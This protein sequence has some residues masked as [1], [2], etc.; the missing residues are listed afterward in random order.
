[1][2]K[3]LGLLI[4]LLIFSSCLY[5]GIQSLKEERNIFKAYF[6]D[7]TG[8]Y[9]PTNTQHDTNLKILK[10]NS[11]VSSNAIDAIKYLHVR[12]TDLKLNF[13]K[14]M[15]I[16]YKDEPLNI[17]FFKAPFLNYKGNKLEL[18]NSYIDTHQDQ[19]LI[20]Q[21]NGLFFSVQIDEFGNNSVLNV[22][23]IKS[24]IIDFISYFEFFSMSKFGLKDI[25]VVKDKLYASIIIEKEP[26]CFTN[27]ILVAQISEILEFNEFF[28]ITD[29]IKQYESEEFNAH[30]TG[31]KMDIFDDEHIIFTTGDF[32]SRW[33]AQDSESLFGKILKINTSNSIAITLAK[34]TRNAQG[35]FVDR[36]ENQI[37]LTE[38]GPQGGD[39]INL[40][41]LN[42]ED[43]NFGWP[44]SSYGG[45]YGHS[46]VNQSGDLYEIRDRSIYRKFPL[47]KSHKDYGFTEP[48]KYFVPS[49]GISDIVKI[50][51]LSLLRESFFIVGAMGRP[52]NATD[53]DMSLSFFEWKQN[54]IE[55]F[56]TITIGERVRDFKVHDNK[57]FFT[58][59]SNALIGL[60]E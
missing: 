23:N 53:Q 32:R 4:I 21:E 37:W 8:R 18:G 52:D 11:K 39:E 5:L 19:L 9:I 25:L 16:D 50:N 1:M 44:I 24:N 57:V 58:T 17:S 40:L 6:S 3:I 56:K 31:G 41:D 36:E 26:R 43:I 59:E 51:E 48:I 42:S 12:E 46:K 60:L 2:K 22:K 45:H 27:S 55:N 20:V 15:A 47:Y 38:H 10:A 35:I 33:L 34:G 7:I 49:I 30:Q 29:C 14:D 13:I 54:Q 28:T